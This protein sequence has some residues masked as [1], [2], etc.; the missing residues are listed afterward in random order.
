M[1]RTRTLMLEAI[2]DLGRRRVEVNRLKG[3]FGA[4]GQGQGEG[5][6]EPLTAGEG[7]ERS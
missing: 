5:E 1:D 4:E 7:G 6:R 2:E 3:V